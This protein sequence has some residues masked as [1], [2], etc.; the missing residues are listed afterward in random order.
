MTEKKKRESTGDTPETGSGCCKVE[1]V[2]SVDERGQMVLPKE[3]REKA[4][5]R[6]GDKL[7]LVSLEKEGEVCCITL[8]KVENLAEMVKG[9][10]SPVMKDILS[11]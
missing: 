6:T 8:F 3:V 10:L 9:L 4:K 5:I 7:A 2:V 1:S 11:D